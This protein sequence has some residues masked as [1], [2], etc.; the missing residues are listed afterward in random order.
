MPKRYQ[1]ASDK[2]STRPFNPAPVVGTQ[3]GMPISY[4]HSVRPPWPTTTAY[5]LSA[6]RSNVAKPENTFPSFDP[7]VL[8]QLWPGQQ[9]WDNWYVHN[10]LNF[11]ADIHGFRVVIALVRPAGASFDSGERIAYFYS[12]D[13]VNYRVGGYL[14]GDAKLYADVREW[15]GSTV[16]RDNGTLQ[17]FYTVS[18]SAEYNGV[19]QTVQRL[20][21]AVQNVRVSDDG[22]DLIFEAPHIHTLIRGCESPDGYFYETPEQAASREEKWPTR[23]RRDNGSDQTENNCDRDPYWF[24]DQRTGKEYLFFEGNTGVGYHP[25]GCIRQEYLG[26]VPVE[27]FCPTED[28]LKANGCVG[29]I[30]LTNETGTYGLRRAPWLVTNLGTDEIERITVIYHQ[31][32]YYLF[33]VCHGNKH[34]L[35]AEQPD[36]VNRDFMLGFRAKTLGGE[37]TPLNGTGV[38]IQQKSYGPAYGGQENNQQ[39][40]YSWQPNAMAGLNAKQF[41]VVTYANFCNVDGVV[42]KQMNAGPSLTIEVDGLTT[43]IVDLVYDIRATGQGVGIAPTTGQL[44]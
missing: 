9:T 5:P 31:E 1:T 34:A 3:L 36:L 2:A 18:H 11:V 32:H 12:K 10:E 27:G 22:E 38:V 15:S 16:Y 44:V 35:N 33:C 6:M 26:D 19:F 29:I 13:G 28:M 24:K 41:S 7:A 4:A 20:A 21:T 42:T 23:H 40:V 43:R 25:A 30:E 37:L 39:Y 14:F 17:T 8:D